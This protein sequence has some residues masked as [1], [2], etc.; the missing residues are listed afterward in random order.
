MIEADTKADLADI[1]AVL[2]E[3]QNGKQNGAMVVVETKTAGAASTP[4]RAAAAYQQLRRR[5]GSEKQKELVRALWQE[6]MGVTADA[7]RAKLGYES[8]TQIAGLLCAITRHAKAVGV[9]SPLIA[10]TRED[11]TIRYELTALGREAFTPQP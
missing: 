7:L 4:T 2:R 5:I 9:D 8:N 10:K 3:P 11:D 1:I 6:R